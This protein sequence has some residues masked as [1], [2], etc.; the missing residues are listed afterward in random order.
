VT[1]FVSNIFWLYEVGFW[2]TEHKDR[3]A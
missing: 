1:T 2:T 3:N